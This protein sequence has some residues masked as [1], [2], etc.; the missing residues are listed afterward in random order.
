MK[1]ISSFFLSLLQE[2]NSQSKGYCFVE[3]AREQDALECMACMNGFAISG[4][5]MKVGVPSG[6]VMPS[7][8]YASIASKPEVQAKF[9]EVVAKSQ[10]LGVF[11]SRDNALSGHNTLTTSGKQGDPDCIVYV[12]AI[13][14]DLTAE[15]VKSLFEP[16]GEVINV[17]MIPVRPTVCASIDR[18]AMAFI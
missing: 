14:Y 11:T 12:A 15:D 7:L 17:N 18:L 8:D 10:D 9:D 1:S 2:L 6:I 16:F 4:R 3:F 13:N 5:P